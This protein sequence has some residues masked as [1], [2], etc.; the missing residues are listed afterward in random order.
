MRTEARTFGVFSRF[1]GNVFSLLMI[2]SL[3]NTHLIA[4]TLSCKTVK[5][6]K[7]PNRDELGINKTY[8][9]LKASHIAIEQ[10]T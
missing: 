9:I 8:G 3:E 4:I 6:K 2:D 10:I 5:K 7:K 1:V